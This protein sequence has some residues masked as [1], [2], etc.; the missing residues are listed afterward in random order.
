MGDPIRTYLDSMANLERVA[1]NAKR[2][3]GTVVGVAS[4]LQRD[5]LRFMFSNS[6]SGLPMDVAFKAASANA[7]DWPT[8]DQIQQ[9]LAQ[10]HHARAQVSQAWNA[11]PQNDRNSLRPP[12]LAA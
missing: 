1:A 7:N 8:A 5:P 2:L 4:A 9:A 12:S 6:A 3:I 11:V 10:W